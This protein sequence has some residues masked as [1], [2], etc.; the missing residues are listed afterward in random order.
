[1]SPTKNPRPSRAALPAA[2]ALSLL[3]VAAPSFAQTAAGADPEI[4]RLDQVS[5]IGSR[6]Q[7]RTV[8]ESPVPIDVLSGD[9][10]R[11]SGYTDVSTILQSLLPSYNFPHPTTPDGNT[12]IRSA[13]LRGLSPDQTLILVNGKR[14]HTSAGSIPAA[15]WAR[16]RSPP[17]S[18]RS[19][20]APLR[21]SRC[22]A[23]APRRNTAPTPSPA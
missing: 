13:T 12:H 3:A 22:C 7:S 5:V 2:V 8:L 17:T 4:K 1:M 16:A 14:R 19:R 11:A 15:R 20:S 21:G 9:E 18:T 10:L 23:T 6:T